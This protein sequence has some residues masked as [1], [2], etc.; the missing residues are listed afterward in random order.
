MR[1]SSKIEKERHEPWAAHYLNYAL[2]KRKQHDI[3]DVQDKPGHEHVFEARKHIFQGELDS[4]IQQM[5]VFYA[6]KSDEIFNSVKELENEINHEENTTLQ[7]EEL[8]DAEKVDLITSLIEK[9]QDQGRRIVHLTRFVSLNMQG[10]RKIL[11]KYAKHQ[12]TMEPQKGYLALEIEHPH[13]GHKFMQGTFLPESLSKE[14]NDLLEHKQLVTATQIIKTSYSELRRYRAELVL[15]SQPDLG[16]LESLDGNSETIEAIFDEMDSTEVHARR[17]AGLVHSKTFADKLAG[18]F[19]PPPEDEAAVAT[20]LGLYLNCASAGLYMANYQLVIPTVSKFLQHMGVDQSAAGL[21]IGCCDIASIPVTVAYSVWTNYSYKSPV[22]CSAIACILGNIIYSASYDFRSLTMLFAARLATGLGSARAVNRRYIADFVS[23]KDRTKASGA[24]VSAN[25]VGMALG[26]LLA[27]PLG[28]FPDLHFHGWTFNGLTMASY[29]MAII[30]ASLL[31]FTIFFFE[32][33]LKHGPRMSDIE[34]A[35]KKAGRAKDEQRRAQRT[36]EGSA[37]AQQPLLNGDA[38]V[39]QGGG[40]ERSS[41]ETRMLRRSLSWR[42]ESAGP[43]DSKKP[44]KQPSTLKGIM[45]STIP[46]TLATVLTLWVSQVVRQAYVDGL[47]AFT[48]TLYGW[49]PGAVGI[50]LTIWG[51]STLPVNWVVGKLSSKVPDR[52]LITGAIIACG[53]GCVGLAMGGYPIWLYLLGGFLAYVGSLVLEGASMSMMSKVIHPSLAKG[54]FNAGLLATES[55]T[56]GRLCGNLLESGVSKATH[57][58]DPDNIVKF[59]VTCYAAVGVLLTLVQLLVFG[60]WRRLKG[61]GLEPSSAP[62]LGSIFTVSGSAWNGNW[63][64]IVLLTIVRLLSDG[65]WRRLKG[66]LELALLAP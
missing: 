49:Q 8:P 3:E 14:L 46:P 16:N 2:L 10:I 29:I 5:L 4:Q 51:F 11:K 56:T 22:I 41:E 60:I 24:F 44:K 13:E 50:L 39:E 18:L 63:E 36:G 47:P 34:E 31:F 17:N 38:D 55:G 66:N 62:D 53:A 32:E 27:L 45:S 7:D 15:H 40:Q 52:V 58:S 42:P 37:S 59:A 33:P 61:G 65:I 19:N 57:A 20:P 54:T 9:L 26:P 43:S 35:Q 25:A 64:S 21:V 12:G 28:K 48:E 23:K 1:F 30:W 6:S